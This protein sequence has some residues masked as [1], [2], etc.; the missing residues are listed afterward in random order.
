VLEARRS[1]TGTTPRAAPFRAAD[2][3]QIP[4]D[5]NGN[6]T[7]KTEGTDTWAYE[8]NAENQLTRVTKNGLE[9][10][11]FGYDPVRRRVEK[12]A[13]GTTTNYL[14]DGENVLREVRAGTTRT[15]VQ[16]QALDESLAMDDGT[17]LSYFHVDALGSIVKV[18]NAA[19][20]VTLTRQY[21]AWGNLEVGADQPGFAFTGREWDSEVG[22]YYYRARYDDP[23]LG[24]FISED[25]I[26]R[27]D[28]PNMYLYARDNPVLF[29]DP[30]GWQGLPPPPGKPVSTRQPNESSKDHYNRVLWAW[31]A[32][33][34][35]IPV[36]W[37]DFPGFKEKPKMFDTLTPA[38]QQSIDR[39]EYAF[40]EKCTASAP[41]HTKRR[42]TFPQPTSAGLFAV[43]CQECL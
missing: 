5:P 4:I 14:Y 35:A 39:W 10:A 18:T 3:C 7:Q 41:P 23:R 16:G 1:T 28:G 29:T 17:S 42:A 27:A 2:P 33:G 34:G 32:C 40:R 21:D 37:E 8:W 43:C 38:Q 9:Q 25:P 19:G 12:V 15:Y 22:L 6:L 30:T 20:A 26:G 36:T 24:R 13:A 31:Q 11:R